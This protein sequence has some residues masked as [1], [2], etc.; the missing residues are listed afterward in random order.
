MLYHLF[1][2]LNNAGIDFPGA[3]LMHYISFRA[4][5]CAVAAILTSMLVGKQIIAKLQKYRVSPR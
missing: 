2:Y 1:E 3:G 5:C 4:I